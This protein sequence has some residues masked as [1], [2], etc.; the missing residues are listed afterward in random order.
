[1][2]F[3]F[4]VRVLLLSL[5]AFGWHAKA[6][7]Y[8]SGG[9]SS[10][11]PH[12]ELAEN[13]P[14]S[15]KPALAPSSYESSAQPLGSYGPSYTLKPAAA[16]SGGRFSG[17]Y[18][19]RGNG[20]SPEGSVS[21]SMPDLLMLQ[22]PRQNSEQPHYQPNSDIN[23]VPQT[24]AGRWDLALPQNRNGFESGIVSSNGIEMHSG[25]QP[26]RPAYPGK[27]HGF[28]TGVRGL[29][30]I[31]QLIPADRKQPQSSKTEASTLPPSSSL[32]NRKLPQLKAG[33]SGRAPPSLQARSRA[34]SPPAV[35][36]AA[37][38]GKLSL[39]GGVVLFPAVSRSSLLQHAS[40][41]ADMGFITAGS[42]AA[43]VRVL[44]SF[45]RGKPA[46]RL[47]V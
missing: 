10:I 29:L 38:C 31:I 20:Y 18:E 28:K 41:P 44:V 24:K 39:S 15:Y 3:G 46:A 40:P 33:P 14:R 17:S 25:Q 7:T 47:R 36:G 5:L 32:T 27:P 37:L 6:L 30:G 34:A 1:M 13:F 4:C 11:E 12:F 26:T 21:S 8:R 23:G 16:P 42:A 43:S 2:A 19:G 22:K 9:S 35:S 45:S